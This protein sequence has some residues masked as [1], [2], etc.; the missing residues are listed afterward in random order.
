M[1]IEI[2]SRGQIRYHLARMAKVGGRRKN[3]TL[4]PIDPPI[5]LVDALYAMSLPVIRSWRDGAANLVLPVYAA[6]LD[7]LSRDEEADQ[8][9]AALNQ[10]EAQASRTV[11]VALSGLRSWTVKV[12][13]W[14][15]NRFVGAVEGATGVKV[16]GVVLDTDATEELALS[17]ERNTDLIRSIGDD[18]RK[19][20]GQAVWQG[21]SARSPRRD[22]AKQINAVIEGQRARARRI[23]VDQTNKLSGALD[24]L[25]Q[26]QAGIDSFRWRHSGKVH[27][28]PEHKARNGKIYRWDDPALRGDKPKMK[29]FCGCTAQAVVAIEDE[30]ARR[31]P[32]W[33]AG[34]TAM[35]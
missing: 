20:I 24:E 17:I 8:V 27:Y 35:P 23:A 34:A 28:R 25:R 32:Q 30:W 1:A 13:N 14:H 21:L 16:Q 29:P 11:V 19:Q 7:R 12:E 15:R 6:A 18:M 3:A 5:A 22:I 33:S 9:T 10:A 31:T 2:T 4:R 26:Q